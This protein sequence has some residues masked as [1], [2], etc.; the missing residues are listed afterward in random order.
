MLKKNEQLIKTF[1][2]RLFYVTVLLLVALAGCRSNKEMTQQ[3]LYFQNNADSSHTVKYDFEPVFQPGDVV[4][5]GVSTED[6]KTMSLFNQ[7]NIVTAGAQGVVSNGSPV[8][9]YVVN[10]DGSMQLPVVGMINVSNTTKKQLASLITTKV[11][12]Y[13]KDSAVVVTVRWLN[14][15]VTVLGEVARPGPISLLGERMTI[16]DALGQA[17]DMT[18]YAR[19]NIKIIREQNGERQIGYIDLHQGNIFDS[20]FYY[21][22]QNDVIYVEMNDR[23][24]IN[25]DQTVVRNIGII[26][27]LVST[28][29]IVVTLVTQIK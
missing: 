28:L 25:S 7:P 19:R 12:E 26:S 4:F 3:L 6:Q 16:L 1:L 17:G 9:G 21:L 5:V 29:A 15:K 27:T 18:I 22:K 24:I 23:K 20:P 2:M 8:S 13:S 10:N 11:K 14:Y